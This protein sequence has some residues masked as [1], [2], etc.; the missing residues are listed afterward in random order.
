MQ[1]KEDKDHMITGKEKQN[2]TNKKDSKPD[3]EHH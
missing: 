2:K 1:H 3:Q